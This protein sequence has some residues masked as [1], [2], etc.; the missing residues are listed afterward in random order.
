MEPSLPMAKRPAQARHRTSHRTRPAQVPAKAGQ[1]THAVPLRGTME[2]RSAHPR[3]ES[4]PASRAVAP[5][6]HPP[7]SGVSPSTS[8][9][10]PTC[11]PTQLLGLARTNC[12]DRP[13]RMGRAMAARRA[14]LRVEESHLQEGR[15]SQ[16]RFRCFRPSSR[17]PRCAF[18]AAE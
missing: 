7:R 3:P 5:S 15:R 17:R 2:V 12:Q 8:L 1:R 6:K 11:F 18:R 14:P 13:R 4:P 9:T 10:S 16:R